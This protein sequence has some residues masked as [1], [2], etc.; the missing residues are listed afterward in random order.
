MSSTVEV[1]VNHW[2]SRFLPPQA[3]AEVALQLEASG[4]VDWF[5]TW[6]QLVSFLPQALWRPDVTPMARLTADCDS[7]YNAGM[8]AVLAATATKKLNI[9]TTLDAVRN[10]PAELLQQVL[11]IAAATPA[12]VALQLAA[13]ELKQCKP[14][15]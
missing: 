11:T 9:T 8:V 7:Y 1:G 12:R 15:G 3:G 4:V 13:G 6:D 5:Q 2:P 14:F 10:G